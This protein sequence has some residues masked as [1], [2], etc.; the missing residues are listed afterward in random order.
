MANGK[1]GPPFKEHPIGHGH[2]AGEH[3]ARS[4]NQPAVPVAERKPY[5]V[6][7]PKPD[8]R[9]DARVHSYW[10]ALSMSDLASV[11]QPID[12]MNAYITCEVLN[13]LYRDRFSTASLIKEWNNMSARLG[14]PRFDVLGALADAEPAIDEDEAEA[15]ASITD[16]RAH[17]KAVEE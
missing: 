10:R 1:P 9:W 2:Y 3:A 5:G 17:L 4:V 8:S 12:W 14:M 16:I 13:V 6:P 7:Q 11:A 15:E